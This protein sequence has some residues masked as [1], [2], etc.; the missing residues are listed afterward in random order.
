M[1]VRSTGGYFYVDDIN[2]LYLYK[3]L[4]LRTPKT[5]SADRKAFNLTLVSAPLNTESAVAH[6]LSPKHRFIYQFF[7]LLFRV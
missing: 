4:D 7:S 2:V 3:K 6:P 5:V 1:H